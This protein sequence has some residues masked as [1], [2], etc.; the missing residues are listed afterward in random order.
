VWLIS[1]AAIAIAIAAFALYPRAPSSASAKPDSRSSPVGGNSRVADDSA[2]SRPNPLAAK[3]RSSAADALASAPLDA[4]RFDG[5]G[6]LR[7]VLVTEPPNVPLPSKWKLTVR[8]SRV[9]VASEGAETRELELGSDGSFAFEGLPLG[10]YELVV[11]AGDLDCPPRQ[12]LLAKPDTSDLFVRLVAHVSGSIDGRVL[13]ASGLGAEGLPVWLE[14]IDVGDVG[15]VGGV[16][17]GGGAARSVETGRGGEFRF[18]HVRDG[19]YRLALESLENP[20][21]APREIV[22]S[23]PHATVPQIELP[24][25]GEMWIQAVDPSGAPL[26]KVEVTGF[27]SNGGTIRATTGADGVAKARFLPPGDYDVIA[28]TPE[29]GRHKERATVT[30]GQTESVRFTM[31]P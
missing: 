6:N 12:V 8:P 23:A 7:G 15:D 5:R 11:D 2:R 28:A 14:P 10:G 4:T 25:L 27:G 19:S 9:L 3:P 29:L 26:A 20:I 24:P 30:A 17:G 18:E 21:G 16:G 1:I 13:E 22:F 31:R